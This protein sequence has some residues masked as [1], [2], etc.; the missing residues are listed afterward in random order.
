[1]RTKR[2][3]LQASI[4]LAWVL[5]I[6]VSSLAGGAIHSGETLSGN[7]AGPSYMESWTFSGNAGDRVL[8]AAVP[9]SGDLNTYLDLYP[10]GGGSA[11]VA[12]SFDIDHQLESSGEYTIVTSDWLRENEG[13]YRISLLK[14]P[15]KVSSAAD[16]DGGPIPSGQTLTGLLINAASDMDAYQFFGN[17]GDRVL[18]TAV[19]T[20]GDLNT[21]L[22]L[23]PPGGGSAE[24]ATSFDI[25]HQL[26]LSGLYTFVVSD[27]LRENAGEYSASLVKI[28]ATQRV[29]IH[30]MSPINSALVEPG[31]ITL[32]WDAVD[33]ATGYDV[34]LGTTATMALAQVATDLSSPGYT[35][36]NAQRGTV[37]YWRV[38]AHTTAGDVLGPYAW[39]LPGDIVPG[40]FDADGLADYG[41]YYPPGGN[42]YIMESTRGLVTAQFGFEDTYPI[43]GDFDGDGRTDYGCYYPAGGNW[44]LSR[45]SK[46]FL[47][48]QFGFAGTFPVTGDFD[49]DGITDYGCY[50]PP[51]GDWYLSQSSGGFIYTQFGYDGTVPVTG[52][53][54]GDGIADYGCYYAPGGDWYLS[55][56]SGGFTYTQFGYSGTVPVSGDFDGDGTADYG[57][58]YPPGGDWYLSRSTGGFIYQQFGFGGTIPVAND[59]D[60]DGQTDIGCYYPP[61]GDWYIQKS[62]EGFEHIQCGF[63]GTVPID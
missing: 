52:D 9:T 17:A 36:V 62:T 1:M 5:L 21:F 44:Y 27:W 50:Y 34:Y 43:T 26:A 46:G 61:E 16:P 31:D 33:G 54:D 28:P 12:T 7:V 37:Y 38:I 42:W 60:G 14:I 39:F 40:D 6:P 47:S 18:I 63:A 11:E 35:A 29:G 41:C 30:G 8:I 22:D 45:S 59:Y 13:D 56:S 25:D 55:K 2:I 20:S 49:G 48:T 19:P 15:G 10:P 57:C 24:A 3:I 53:F 51:G 58:Y 4:S 32:N 23:Y